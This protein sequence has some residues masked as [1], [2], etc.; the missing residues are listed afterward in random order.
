[1]KKNL[2]LFICLCFS[3]S[4]SANAAE[5]L[6]I[7]NNSAATSLDLEVVDKSSGNVVASA[8]N[9]NYLK[10]TTKLTVPANAILTLNFYNAGTTT[11]FY[12]ND[13]VVY[14]DNEFRILMLYG[15]SSSIRYTSFTGSSGASSGSMLK[16]DFRHTTS[17]LEEIDLLVRN[18]SHVMA[19]NFQYTD[20]TFTFD[21]QISAVDYVLDMTPS[22][23]NNTGLF[24]W[25]LDGASLGG[26]YIVLFTAGTA[27]NLGM[28]MVQMD[29]TVTLLTPVTSVVGIDDLA[30]NAELNIDIYPNPATDVLTVR[31]SLTDENTSIQIYSYAGKLV[32]SDFIST[33]NQLFDLSS[34]A[35]GTY[36]VK[37]INTERVFTQKLIVQ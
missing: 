34:L 26:E 8:T 32:L 11:K 12:N 30:V 31:S 7:N 37:A 15:S 21:N 35:K 19:N 27:Q 4:F 28:Y 17:D 36:I 1:M 29:G 25:E 14:N 6:F 22:G 24:A 10:A 18:N 3:A 23:N 2:L 33:E 9:I 5:I 13:N 20:G 16:Y